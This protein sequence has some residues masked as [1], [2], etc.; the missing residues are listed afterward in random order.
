MEPFAFAEVVL[1]A[2]RPGTLTYRVP[3]EW[4]GQLRRGQLVQVPFGKGQRP[5]LVVA[6]YPPGSDP[7]PGAAA[8]QDIAR[9]LSQEP[10]VGE[11]EIELAYWLSDRYLAPLGRCL[12]LF[13]PRGSLARRDWYVRLKDAEASGETLFEHQLLGQ[14]RE[15]GPLW[16]RQ[17]SGRL[18]GMPWRQAMH[19]LAA[20]GAVDAELRA[21]P[22][23]RRRTAEWLALGEAPDEAPPLGYPAKKADLLDVIQEAGEAG[24][25][26]AEA[27]AAAHTTRR[28]LH[29]L[30]KESLVRVEKAP[31]GDGEAGAA[32]R[33]YLTASPETAAARAREWRRDAGQRE[34]LGWLQEARGPALA[35]RT[36]GARRSG[37]RPAEVVG[38][39]ADRQR[40]CATGGPPGEH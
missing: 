5:G 22:P 18:K 35:G 4:A 24:L 26:L 28:T 34:I 17:L 10:L 20:R 30:A 29:R 38:G 33:V 23:T 16:G 19:G 15:N 12:W 39:R 13:V 9:I 27:L 37:G 8:S 2:G 11:R 3:P 1:A 7:H 32:E 36:A 6:A 40:P 21:R 25:P 14:L 31:D